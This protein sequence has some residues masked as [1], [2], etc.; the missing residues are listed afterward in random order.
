M[1]I[2]QHAKYPLMFSPL[3]LG[4][5]Q[6]KNRVLM[7]SMHTLLEEQEDGFHKVATYY[8]ERAH[9][10]VGMIMT[11]GYS[12]NPEGAS[13]PGFSGMYS[14]ADAEQHRI[15]TNAVHSAA[16]DCKICMQILHAGRYAWHKDSVA[17]S[18]IKSR[19]NPFTPNELS[20]DGIQK[21][22]KQDPRCVR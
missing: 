19:I 15:I 8:A 12:P 2:H 11:G 6:L 13:G 17:P 4:F 9:G 18:P 3:D 5:T 22:M 21:Q 7:G 20:D 16:P 10:G 14:E 1:G